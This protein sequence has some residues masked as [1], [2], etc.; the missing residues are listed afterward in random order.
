[1]AV[2]MNYLCAA[3][4][5]APVTQPWSGTQEAAYYRALKDVPSIGLLELPVH[6]TGQIHAQ[7]PAW[8]LDQ[9]DKRWDFVLS[10][11]GGTLQSLQKD[12]QFGLASDSEAGRTAALRLAEQTRQVVKQINAKFGR[13]AVRWVELHTAPR[14]SVAGVTGSVAALARSLRELQGWDWDGAG[15][16]IEHCDRYVENQR[17]EKG[18]LSIEQEIDA[19]QQVGQRMPLGIVINWGRSALEARDPAEPLKHVRAAKAAGLLK[20]LTFSGCTPQ[21]PNYGEW[22]DQ[23]APFAAT[24]GFKTGC[25]NSVLTVER[26]AEC[27]KEANPVQLAFVGLKVQPL[28]ATLN[29]E[30]RLATLRDTIALIDK[31]MAS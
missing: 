29:L 25:A 28:P 18:F 30:Q 8:Q 10:L 3:Y 15:L 6:A 4:N 23:H 26:A 21:D 1:M 16:V 31:A 20:G 11:I 2:L 9:L 22:L 12:P 7:D 5:A 17:P 27:L 19:I 13:K 14:R 24:P